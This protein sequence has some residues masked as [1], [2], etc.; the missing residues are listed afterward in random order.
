[1]VLEEM[2]G[3]P[4]ILPVTFSAACTGVLLAGCNLSRL[5]VLRFGRDR[6]RGTYYVLHDPVS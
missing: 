3:V 2:A 5:W 1:M 4:N 6:E